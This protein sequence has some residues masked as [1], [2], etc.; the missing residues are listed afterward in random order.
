MVGVPEEE[1]KSLAPYIRSV[2]SQG[3]EG[4]EMDTEGLDVEGM[5]A[6][7]AADCKAGNMAQI[8]GYHYPTNYDLLGYENID[9]VV[10]YLEL[11][12]DRAL[13]EKPVRNDARYSATLR[14]MNIRVYA[15]C[16]N[17]LRWME[18][19]GLLTEEMQREIV[20]KYGGA[21][22]AYETVSVY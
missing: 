14:Y 22:A 7:I 18:E 15:S 12:I 5:L 19:N 3:R 1:L 4:K 9:C 8:S 2:Y 21:Y 10:A 17:T 16:E 6:A 13:L 11:G 20:E